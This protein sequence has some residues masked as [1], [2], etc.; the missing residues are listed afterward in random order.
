MGM[1]TLERKPSH[2]VFA[3]SIEPSPPKACF[4]HST[5]LQ[6]WSVSPVAEMIRKKPDYT[7]PGMQAV[8]QGFQW[9]ILPTPR[10][11]HPWLGW[12]LSCMQGTSLDIKPS[13]FFIGKSDFKTCDALNPSHQ[14]FAAP[15]KPTALDRRPPSNHRVFTH[16]LSSIRA[17]TW[18]SILQYIGHIF[19]I[20]SDIL[21]GHKWNIKT[22]CTTW[23]SKMK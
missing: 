12:W 3:I 19:L 9:P 17:W 23:F 8:N 11:F 14:G 20:Q 2:Q 13:T 10:A 1:S 22:P 15:P 4:W 7:N 5:T 21:F 16:R 6:P 18:L